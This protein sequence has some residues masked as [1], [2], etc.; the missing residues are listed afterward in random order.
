VIKMDGKG[1]S[2]VQ[3]GKIIREAIQI[4]GIYSKECSFI[5]NIISYNALLIRVFLF[6]GRK[7][8]K[9][10]GLQKLLIKLKR[11]KYKKYLVIN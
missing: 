10:Y 8:L 5:Q 11:T 7:I 9:M 6:Y 3:E 2:S 1:I 4:I